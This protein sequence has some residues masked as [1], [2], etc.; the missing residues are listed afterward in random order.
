MAL[1]GLA[2][3]VA[4]AVAATA[5]IP[6]YREWGRLAIAPYAAAAG[7]ALGLGLA[8]RRPRLGAGMGRAGVALAAAAF[9][10]AGALP[11]ALEVRWRFGGDL[12]RHAQSE[13]IVTEE[14]ARALVAGRDPYAATFVH[15]P[16]AARPLGTT[17]HFP[18]LPGMLAFGLP[19]AALP[20]RSPLRDAR[21]WF[22]AAALAAAWA[23]LRRPPPAWERRLRIA[24]VLLVLPTGA[25]LLATGGD[26]LPVLALMLLG[27]VLLD[28]DRPVAAGLALGLAAATK[29]TAWMLAP[30]ALVAAGRGRRGRMAVAAGAVVLAVVTP[31]VAWNPAAFVQDVIRFPL[32]LGRRP[33]AA[34]TATLGSLLLRAAPGHRAALTVVLVLAVAAAGVALLVIRPPRTAGAAAWRAG[35]LFVVA[36]ALAPAARLGYAVYPI[37]LLVWGAMLT[38]AERRPARAGTV[39]TPTTPTT[40][41]TT[42]A[43]AA[44]EGE[45]P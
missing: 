27:T 44:P 17:T 40:T 33:S 11:L 21:I 1:Y 29:Q 36:V 28:R 32:G 18:Y 45:H 5:A 30:F 37:D 42:A 43:A 16:L 15:G 22:A 6:Q 9:V 19:R 2:A 8:A 20:D 7:L 12:G 14:A 4:V 24:Q 41:M 25:L 39:E 10:L 26:D 23:A 3:L 35:L 31:F 34:G 38:R 13:A